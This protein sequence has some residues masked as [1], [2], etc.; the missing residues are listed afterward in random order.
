MGIGCPVKE[1][2][3]DRALLKLTTQLRLALR[4]QKSGI[5]GYSGIAHIMVKLTYIGSSLG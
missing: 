4:V 3:T 2:K 5:S 1:G